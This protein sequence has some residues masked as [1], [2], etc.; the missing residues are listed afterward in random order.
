[1]NS[2]RTE[3]GPAAH[4]PAYAGLRPRLLAFALD[5]LPIAASLV[6]LTLVSIRLSRLFPAAAGRLFAGPLAGQTAGFLTVTLP[7]SL[8]FA[9]G[10]SSPARATWGKRRLGLIVVSAGG[11]RL[12]RPRSLARTSLKFAPWELAHACIWQLQFRPEA[13]SPLITAGLAL[14]WLLVG[15]NA[16]AL[17]LSETRQTLYDRL[18]GTSVISI[19]RLEV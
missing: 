19:K 6:G 3:A 11:E 17:L 4:E 8:Y 13:A 16:A 2:S 1:M 5:Y 12:S 7:V 10:E 14:V 9:L 15:A 18:A